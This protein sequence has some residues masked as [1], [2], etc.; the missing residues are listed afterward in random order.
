MGSFYT[1]ITLKAA[2]T[3]SVAAA[4]RKAGRTALI[5]PSPYGD[6]G[7]WRVLTVLTFA[8]GS[9]G[10]AQAPPAQ[11]RATEEMRISGAD[12]S[13]VSFSTI[14]VRRDGRIVVPQSRDGQLRVY[15]AAGRKLGT[16][17]RKGP[18]PGEFNYLDGTMGWR[19][20][21][22]WIFD[23]NNQRRLTFV[24]NDLKLV[25]TQSISADAAKSPA[26]T[27]EARRIPLA[28]AHIEKLY[29]DGSMLV[30]W[31]FG[32]VHPEFRSRTDQR[33]VIVNIAGV[34]LRELARIPEEVGRI[35][36]RNATG[37]QYGGYVPFSAVPLQSMSS[38]GARVG[39]LSTTTMSGANGS[40]SVTV[41]RA[42]GDT[43]FTKTY[44]YVGLRIS[45]RAKDSVINM[46][47][48][49]G[50]ASSP[51]GPGPGDLLANKA[52]PLMP[53][54]FAPVT[55]FQL[56]DDDT[57]WLTV[58]DSAPQIRYRA[59]DGKGN[60]LGDVVLPS[61]NRLVRATRS[62]LWVLEYDADRVPSIVRYRLT[63]A[64]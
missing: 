63:P 35:V 17:G 28:N 12:E 22:L 48:Q 10:R 45:Q 15:D 57:A 61:N 60:V 42:A 51:E 14:L 1:N 43:A 29:G 59:L 6:C 37:E 56:G 21:T 25:R 31:G 58:F 40:Y 52:R 33:F 8:I 7:M 49:R 62:Q 38:D 32:P 46:M 19:G 47:L 50:K 5:V 30:R 4:I 39:L 9:A 41:I 16:F 11:F 23:F 27:A 20:D 36:A 55:G 44:S 26:S 34:I 64:R 13:F 24:S 54:T 3:D 53:E 2:D 18:G